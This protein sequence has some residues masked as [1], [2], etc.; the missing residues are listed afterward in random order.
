[1][2]INTGYSTAFGRNATPS[3][4]AY[5]QGHALPA[6]Q[7][8]F[9]QICFA[10]LVSPNGVTDLQN[11]IFRGFQQIHKRQPT[12]AEQQEWQTKI[13]EKKLM[14]H[15]FREALKGSKVDVNAGYLA[16]F[17]RDATPEEKAYW[18]SQ[19]LPASQDEF[20]KICMDYLTSPKGDKEL[21]LMI[22]RGYMAMLQRGPTAEEQQV[23]QGKIKATK[24]K[25]AD[26]TKSLMPLSMPPI[27]IPGVSGDTGEA[28]VAPATSAKTLFVFGVGE[29]KALWYTKWNGGWGAW[30]RLGGIVNGGPDA[31]SP[32]PGEI[33]VFLRANDNTIDAIGYE[34]GKGASPF[35][36]YGSKIGSDPSVVCR[37]G[38]KIDLFA[39]G[40]NNTA[41]YHTFAEDGRWAFY[42]NVQ[43]GY[44]IEDVMTAA[45][46]PAPPEKAG[47]WGNLFGVGAKFTT[48]P[49]GWSL[50]GAPLGGEIKGSP[51]ACAFGGVKRAVFARGMND[52]IWWRYWDGSQWTAWED[53]GGLK[54]SSDPSAISRG[55]GMIDIFARG[56]NNHL[57]VRS[58]KN[59]IWTPWFS[60][61]GILSG[62]PDATSWGGN[63]IDVFGRGADGALWHAWR[64]DNKPL[65][66]QPA[67]EN[68]GGKIIADPTAVGVPW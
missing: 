50:G 21:R 6:S 44:A 18:Q 4:L 9:N 49:E 58:Y 15:D 22:F 26:L 11:V 45:A 54:M 60:W 56:E 36:G 13:K 43:N 20:E 39:R 40:H 59:G 57:Y 1:M 53:L 23:W 33:V 29:D 10:Y 47:F 63:R 65:G 35:V 62:G 2:D 32:N 19:A 55:D 38:K 51:D 12:A 5:W 31:C 30:E 17:G 48:P 61:G 8:E 16:T 68:V 3:E 7:E 37:A 14:Y 27:I 46:N 66:I 41:L 24:M 25:Y 52:Y 64:D 42:Y 28:K 34:M 67:W